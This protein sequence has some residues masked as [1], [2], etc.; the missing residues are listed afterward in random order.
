MSSSALD[1]PR[2]FASQIAVKNIEILSPLFLDLRIAG[3]L[4]R[5]KEVVHDLEFVGIPYMT[6]TCDMFGNVIS[7][8]TLLDEQIS[9]IASRQME[10][11]MIKNGPKYKQFIL[12]EGIKLDLFIVTPPAQFGVIYT[13]RTGPADFSHWLVTARR[14]GGGMPS[15]MSVKDGALWNGSKLIETPTEEALFEAYGL[16]YIRPENRVAQWRGQPRKS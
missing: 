16:D 5:G 7:T 12:P 11:V 8:K 3:S 4:R 9:Q 14:N 6:K 10:A 13:I 2:E 15:W 1:Y